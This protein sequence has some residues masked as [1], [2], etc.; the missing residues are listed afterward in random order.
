MMY[1]SM[2]KLQTWSQCVY[3]K[4]FITGRGLSCLDFKLK[5]LNDYNQEKH[6]TSSLITLSFS[7]FINF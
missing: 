7:T 2:S 5:S 3:S 6:Y 1:A 4:V